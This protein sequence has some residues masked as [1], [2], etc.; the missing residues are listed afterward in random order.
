MMNDI[1]K[2]I[3][4]VIKVIINITKNTKKLE[5]HPQE[6]HEQTMKFFKFRLGLRWPTLKN[7]GIGLGAAA[8]T[9]AA[10]A[11][12][13]YGHK[14]LNKGKIGQSGYDNSHPDYKEYDYDEPQ[15]HHQSSHQSN[16]SNHHKEHEKI[17]DV[18]PRGPRSDYQILEVSPNAS[19]AEIKKSYHKLSRKLHPDKGGDVAEFQELSNAYERLK[20]LHGGKVKRKS[21]KTSPW[22]S[23]VK[24]FAAANGMN[25][26]EA[27]KDPRC[28]NSYR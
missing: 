14:H 27:L 26:P 28:K 5:M 4:K 22:I 21:T 23:H 10:L 6:A 12:A 25:Y 2:I 13:Y 20:G 17:R 3:I 19:M 7:V 1:I 24:K 15:S 18:P 8:A 11:G 16:Q 9:A